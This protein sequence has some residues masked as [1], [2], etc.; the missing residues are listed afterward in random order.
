MANG[1]R[2]HP[3]HAALRVSAEI[4]HLVPHHGR[5]EDVAAPSVLRE[6]TPVE[7]QH[8]AGRLLVQGHELDPSF[9]VPLRVGVTGV[10]AHRAGSHAGQGAL[11]EHHQVLR[12]LRGEAPALALSQGAQRPIRRL[13]RQRR[14]GG[15][16][17][18][19]LGLAV[20][21][22]LGVEAAAA[23]AGDRHQVRQLLVE[24]QLSRLRRR[25]HHQDHAQL[26]L[27]GDGHSPAR[28]GAPSSDLLVLLGHLPV[29][30]VLLRRELLPHDQDAS[31]Q[32]LG[33]GQGRGPPPR[34]DGDGLRRVKA[35]AEHFLQVLSHGAL[36]AGG[37]ALA[38]VHQQR[39][40]RGQEGVLVDHLQGG[41]DSDGRVVVVVMVVVVTGV[42]R[43]VVHAE[44][45]LPLRAVGH[46][47]L[48]ASAAELQ[49]LDQA[50]EVRSAVDLVVQQVLRV[51]QL[52]LR[53]LQV[54]G[55]PVQ[56]Q[57]P[58]LLAL[59]RGLPAPQQLPAALRGRQR[60]ALLRLQEEAEVLRVQAL[61]VLRQLHQ[62]EVDVGP[63][64]QL[65]EGLVELLAGHVGD[66]GDGHVLLHDAVAVFVHLGEL[67]R[68][69][70]APHLPPRAAVP[71]QT[72]SFAQPPRS[73]A[74]TP[75][76]RGVGQQTAEDATYLVVVP[77]DDRE[78][79]LLGQVLG[80][81][82][83]VAE[84]LGALPG[85]DLSDAGDVQP[86]ALRVLLGRLPAQAA[87]V[88][89]QRVEAAVDP[90]VGPDLLQLAAALHERQAVRG[91][92][93]LER[94]NPTPTL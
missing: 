28:Q 16:G 49:G 73:S 94:D 51:Q 2:W 27:T 1:L 38:Q 40:R 72:S 41:A 84:R 64:A 10:Q 43:A 30:A 60:Q 29:G 46:S 87:E 89:V 63:G 5:P 6:A 71:R 35:G 78:G 42:I 75:D 15:G 33:G 22:P 76:D 4:R 52:A 83:V 93:H 23:R 26:L 54:A 80:E 85:A 86:G 92:A 17:A 68:Q 82:P 8:G 12:A 24:A 36:L 34:A 37:A 9:P 65:A 47:Q 21:R 61:A 90:G 19:G 57:Q 32:L 70:L 20:T 67:R 91:A 53:R 79:R 62:Q 48:H 81:R 77:V 11:G 66:G 14:A 39:V 7:V 25:R 56:T 50:A 18:A 44:E 31:L 88:A 59:G 74:S 55:E 45:R 69:P 3:R 58:P 13:G